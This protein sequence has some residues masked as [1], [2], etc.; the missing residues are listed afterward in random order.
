MRSWHTS[1][2][3]N[4]VCV[5][6]VY[7]FTILGIMMSANLLRSKNILAVGKKAELGLHFLRLL[8]INFICQ[9]LLW[10]FYHSSIG[11]I[12]TYCTSVGF[13]LCTEASCR[14]W[15]RHLK[16]LLAVSSLPWRTSTSPDATGEQSRQFRLHSTLHMTTIVLRQTLQVLW[17]LV[18]QAERCFFPQAGEAG[19][20]TGCCSREAKVSGSRT[21]WPRAIK[22]YNFAVGKKGN[23]MKKRRYICMFLCCLLKYCGWW[24]YTG[25]G[26][27]EGTSLKDQLSS[28]Q[29]HACIDKSP[30]PLTPQYC[31]ARPHEARS[32]MY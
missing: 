27:A 10:S 25:T 16:T 21:H 2:H 15:L 17:N 6:S 3:I 28:D 8:R 32:K 1:P 23:R 5:E 18:K 26:F 31:N 7:S 22:L 4:G 11:S 14:G 20:A 9:K 29:A 13:T 24:S 30:S 19:S 12:L